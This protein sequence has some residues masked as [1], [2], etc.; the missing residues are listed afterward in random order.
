VPPAGR[1][2]SSATTLAPAIIEYL[3][4]HGLDHDV[5]LIEGR[6]SEDPDLMKPSPYLV[7]AAVGRLDTEGARCVFVGDSA[8]D[9]L[10]GMLAGVPVIGYAPSPRKTRELTDAGARALV[11][12]MSDITTAIH[13]VRRPCDP[14]GD[15]RQISAS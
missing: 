6:E 2:P 9:V 8:A 3:R 10:A 15:L 1:S 13:A 5:A 11:T 14:T 7:R 4:L 12:S